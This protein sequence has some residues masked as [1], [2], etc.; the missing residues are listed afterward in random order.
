MKI[1]VSRGLVGWAHH[2]GVQRA[3]YFVTIRTSYVEVPGGHEIVMAMNTDM[4]KNIP[5]FKSLHAELALVVRAKIERTL[6]KVPPK[7]FSNYEPHIH[8]GRRVV[9]V[10]ATS[11][12]CAAVA[13]RNAGFTVD[14][15][16]PYQ[17]EPW[18]ELLKLFT[19]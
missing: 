8:L 17:G 3:C 19:H 15:S 10:F 1:F 16:Y 5:S 18:A 13:A 14:R 7:P 12:V 11:E 9:D 4:D 2:D 6:V